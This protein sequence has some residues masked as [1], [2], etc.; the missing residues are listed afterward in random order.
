MMHLLLFL[1]TLLTSALC[2]PAPADDHRGYAG[3]S[4]GFIVLTGQTAV[5]PMELVLVVNENPNPHGWY[6]TAPE[7]EDH[8]VEG[9]WTDD[10]M[11]L[12]GKSGDRLSLKYMRE[13]SSAKPTDPLSLFVITRLT[14]SWS[15]LS[16]EQP[17]TLQ[18]DFSRGPLENGRWYDFGTS[19]A[20]IEKNAQAFLRAVGDGDAPTAARYV[21]YPLTTFLEK[22][23]VKIR[24][25][26]EFLRLYNRIF[27]AGTAEK[28]RKALPHDMFSRNW[29]A[30]VE[31][32]EVWFSDKGAVSEWLTPV[33]IAK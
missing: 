10:G 21:D 7:F 31:N 29:N 15:S 20:E 18:M 28:A 16:G 23:T 22:K 27:R 17:L 8:P 13:H 25:S 2:Q 33:P 30:M 11:V 14:G 19:D 9:S 32:G 6:F 12:E 5:V 3:F 1:C 24:N 4:A 26:R